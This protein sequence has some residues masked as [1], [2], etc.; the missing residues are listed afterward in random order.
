MFICVSYIS[1]SIQ[2]GLLVTAIFKLK[3]KILM[4][5]NISIFSHL[6]LCLLL[7]Y[8]TWISLVLFL[9]F[10]TARWYHMI[11]WCSCNLPTGHAEI[12]IFLREI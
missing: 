1:T 11:T 3:K 5:R 12:G 4:N 2:T 10:F 6:K 7:Q 8:V 9:L